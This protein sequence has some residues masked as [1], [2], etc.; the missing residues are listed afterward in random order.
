VGGKFIP[1]C[2]EGKNAC[3]PEDVGGIDGFYDFLEVLADPDDEQYEHHYREWS[4]GDYNPKVFDI[5]MVN[6]KLS[7]LR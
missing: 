6:K 7:K 2:L 3:P 1:V 4:G 5:D